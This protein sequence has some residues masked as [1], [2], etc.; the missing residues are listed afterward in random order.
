MF[1]V[2][3]W[4]PGSSIQEIR[5]LVEASEDK[6]LE[7]FQFEKK[8]QEET[9]HV[10]ED[11][12]DNISDEGVNDEATVILN[13][14]KFRNL[15]DKTKV[16]NVE[17][18]NKDDRAEEETLDEI[19]EEEAEL[20][21]EKTISSSDAT[22]VLSLDE[23]KD[24]LLGESLATE[25]QLKES[26]EI[27]KKEEENNDESVEQKEEIGDPNKEEKE[28]KKKRIGIVGILAV[29]AL[30]H[31]F[32]EEEPKNEKLVPKTISLEF[33][34]PS[35]TLD[36]LKSKKLLEAGL[37]LLPKIESG[38]STFEENIKALS[39]FKGALELHFRKKKENDLIINESINYLVYLY[40]L[41]LSEA[42]DKILA[43]ET[44]YGLIKLVQN[45][46]F[47]DQYVALGVA[48][49]YLY[50]KKV[51]AARST[52]E[53]YLRISKKP[54]LSIFITYLK[55][56][57]EEGDFKLARDLYTKIK[58][59]PNLPLDGYL[60]LCDFLELDGRT[61]EAKELLKQVGQNNQNN[62][63]ILLKYAEYLLLDKDYQSLD[64]ILKVVHKIKGNYSKK[65][66]AQYYEYKGII[67]AAQGDNKKAVKYFNYSLKVSESSRLRRR[68]ADLSIGGEGA[69]ETLIRESKSKVLL[70]KAKEYVDQQKFNLAIQTLVKA[71]DVA[72]DFIDSRLYFSKV[73]LRRGLFNA[74][75]SS[76]ELLQTLYPNENQI[77]VA[78][79]RAYIQSYRTYEAL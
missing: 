33:P 40:S 2:G 73:Q 41:L 44:T 1:P 15:D 66:I 16:I 79:V 18:F 34:A 55:V 17:N 8:E 29:L 20:E 49:Y 14:R 39:A 38:I 60:V 54:S 64:L 13:T 62:S 32:M 58:D 22:T 77:Q 4:E 26:L 11:P 70:N 69:V 23:V 67:S 9:S 7:E 43:G 57:I 75:I 71:C 59:V 50:F 47:T 63:K 51:K 36:T 53:N 19:M 56:A 21:E 27:K 72:P 42:K 46:V 5:D 65:N 31:L 24:E 12:S 68:L 35:E 52:I 25:A 37:I 76:L 6:Q 74:G 48:N 10:E 61:E 3:S 28:K 30:M 78:L 45:R